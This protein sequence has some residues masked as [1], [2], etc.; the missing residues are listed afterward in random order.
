MIQHIQ[1]SCKVSFIKGSLIILFEDNVVYIAQIKGGYIKETFLSSFSHSLIS[2][3][4]YNLHFF[5][6]FF[7]L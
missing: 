7:I 5:H 6:L 2:I 3:L 1:E 4:F